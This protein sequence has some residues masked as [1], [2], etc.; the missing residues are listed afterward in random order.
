LVLSSVDGNCG[1]L[2][3]KDGKVPERAGKGLMGFYP[4]GFMAVAA[5]VFAGKVSRRFHRRRRRRS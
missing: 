3:S 1:T 2:P 4:A 5:S